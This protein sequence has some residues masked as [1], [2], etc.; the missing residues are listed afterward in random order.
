MAVTSDDK[1]IISGS[2]D[3][4]I[5]IFDFETKQQVHHFQEAHK[6]PICSM[7]ITSDDRYMI[8]GSTGG[9]IKVF[10]IQ[11]KQEVHDFDS[12]HESKEVDLH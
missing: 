4:S 6:A 11:T 1:Y 2:S 12:V 5:K 7:T 9:S 10:D 8:A 3:K